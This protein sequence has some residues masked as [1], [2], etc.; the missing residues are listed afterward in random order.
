MSKRIL[1]CEFHEESNTFNPV[2]NPVER[3]FQ[4]LMAGNTAT[5]GAV[6]AFGEAGPYRGFLN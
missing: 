4:K 5:H 3:P 6:D 2:V 1:I